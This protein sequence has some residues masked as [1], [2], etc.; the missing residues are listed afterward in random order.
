M[1]NKGKWKS[2]TVSN[3]INILAQADAHIGSHVELAPPW[4][5]LSVKNLEETKRYVQCDLSPSSRNH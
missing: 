5:R 4:L 3:K 1:D 2:F